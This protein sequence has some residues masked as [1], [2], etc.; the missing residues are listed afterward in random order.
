MECGYEMLPIILDGA[1]TNVKLVKTTNKVLNPTTNGKPTPAT[2]LKQ[3][4]S[5]L[6]KGQEMFPIFCVPHMAKIFRNSLFAKG[7]DFTYPKLTLSCGFTLEAGTCR[8]KWV[9]K[10]HHKNKE[11]IVSSCRMPKNAYVHNLN[12]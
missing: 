7:N 10:L 12:K 5:F 3:E 11:K 8:V 4:T 1:S 9:R 6:C 2:Q